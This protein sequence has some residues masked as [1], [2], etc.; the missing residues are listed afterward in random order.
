MDTNW[1]MAHDA[2]VRTCI[3]IAGIPISELRDDIRCHACDE[4][5][6]LHH[7]DPDVIEILTREPW[8]ESC[9]VGDKPQIDHTNGS[10]DGA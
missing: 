2:R 7:L 6:R 3:V 5:H 10:P 8:C 4:L 1:E 9:K